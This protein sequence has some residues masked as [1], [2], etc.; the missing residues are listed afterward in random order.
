[1]LAKPGTDRVNRVPL[2]LPV[3]FLRLCLEYLRIAITLL[4]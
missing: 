2:R 4:T 3:S 1:M